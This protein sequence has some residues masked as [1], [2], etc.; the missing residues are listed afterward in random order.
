MENAK[1]IKIITDTASDITLE[2]ANKY[3]IHLIPINLNIN[4]TEYKDKYDISTDEF[5]KILENCSELPKTSQI[6][7]SQ[8]Y[9]TFK[10]FSEYSIIYCPISSKASGSASSAFMA[11]NMIEEETPESDI[12]I[13][14]CE[15]FSYCYGLWVIEAAKMAM[16]NASKDEIVSMIE[17]KI[18]KTEAM[19]AVDDLKY[20][21]KGGRISSAENIVAN[22]LDIKPVLT[23]KDGLVVSFDKVRGSK[24]LYSKLVEILKS[25]ALDDSNQSIVIYH[26]NAPDKAEKIKEMIV[27][28]TCFNNF[29]IVE[30]GPT[31]GIHTGPGALALSYIKK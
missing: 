30:I 31:I 29:V 11:K 14:N 15:T 20:L 22:V 2:L 26:S 28:N 23:I 27:E 13:I 19:F 4:G 8:H 6:T 25:N 21:K 18:S 12:T 3:N 24:K 5:Y 16:N 17:E 1:K 10:E 9:D 7:V